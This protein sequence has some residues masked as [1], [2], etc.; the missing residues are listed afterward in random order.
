MPFLLGFE[1]AK[2]GLESGKA[3]LNYPLKKPRKKILEFGYFL[4]KRY[5]CSGGSCDFSLIYS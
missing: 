2:N 5:P 1:E 4:A 3:P